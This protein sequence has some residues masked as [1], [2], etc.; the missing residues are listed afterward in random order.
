[1]GGEKR[2]MKGLGAGQTTERVEEKRV[3]LDKMNVTGN[4]AA[5]SPHSADDEFATTERGSN[6]VRNDVSGGASLP[7]EGVGVRDQD[8]SE[9]EPADHDSPRLEFQTNRPRLR[10]PPRQGLLY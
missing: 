7:C 5:S 10:P 9:G 6:V 2:V 4:G 8:A 3:S 1:M